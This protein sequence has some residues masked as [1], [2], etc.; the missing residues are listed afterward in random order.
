M[1]QQLIN[2]TRLLARLVPLETDRLEDFAR[3]TSLELD[4]RVTIIDIQGLPLAETERPVDELEN[5]LQRP[6]IQAALMGKTEINRRYSATLGTDMV[7]AAAP[8]LDGD[9]NFAAVLRLA[10]SLAQVTAAVGQIRWVIF[11]AML[12]GMAAVW[13]LS[14]VLTG[15]FTRSLAALTRKARDFGRGHFRNQ[16]EIA[17][18]DEI[19]QLEQVFNEMG[20]NI[21]RVMTSLTRER[22][23][24]E[25]ILRQLPVGVMVVDRE[26]SVIAVNAVAQDILGTTKGEGLLVSQL[27]R[28]YQVN[29]FVGNL[30]AEGQN[31]QDEVNILDEAGRTKNIR[32]SGATVAGMN[33]EVVIVLQD[34]T[35]LRQLEQQRKDL[36]ANISHEL[37]TPLTAIRGFAETVLDG[38]LDQDTARHFLDIIR[39]ESLHLSRLLNE[40][41]NLSRL[42]S[43]FR[44]KQGTSSVRQVAREAAELLG[45]MAAARE[46]KIEIDM[47]TDVQVAVEQDYLEQIIVNYID[48]AIKYTP[49]GTKIKITADRMDDGFV[50]IAVTDNGPGIPGED[51]DRLF[52]RFFRVEKSRKREAGGTGLGLT[53]VKHVVEGFGGQVGVVSHPQTGTS[54]WA[55]LP[56]KIQQ[57]E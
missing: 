32:L 45:D 38:Q 4:L 50:R 11:G 25:H 26:G 9:G 18:N 1:E 54:F 44:R 29:K 8:V 23:R 39:S 57:S 42:E 43:G 49:P 3:Q 55:T 30:L 35:D 15:T 12:T 22:A 24:V 13:I 34:I 56:A 14:A 46:T 41:L 51:Q 31:K 20:D 10:R 6:E 16:K 2:D 48:N 40:L 21:V 53:I 52:Q 27:T 37:R 33:K 19:G 7:Y 36:V 28:N 5:H 47:A 17:S